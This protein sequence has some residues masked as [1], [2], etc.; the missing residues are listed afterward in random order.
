MLDR[1]S[2]E[3]ALAR[4][5]ELEAREASRSDEQERDRIFGRL[6]E[7]SRAGMYLHQD[8]KIVLVNEQIRR[9]LDY[10][11]QELLGA[12]FIEFVH[13]DDR[14]VVAERA[15]ARQ[16][17][18]EAPSTYEFRL[19]RRDG[20]ILWVEVHVE[21]AEYRG[22]PA[23]AGSLLDV[24]NRKIAEQTLREERDKKD[25]LYQE[26]VRNAPA[27][28][29]EV[30]L[31]SGRLI[32]VNEVV[33]QYSGYTQ[34]ELLGMKPQDLFAP[35]SRERLEQRMRA[36]AAD[37]DVESATE[38]QLVAR[39]GSDVWV[40]V[41]T[42]VVY[43]D[44]KPVR[45]RSVASDIT[46]RKMAEE[47]LNRRVA[48]EGVLTSISSNF[49][50]LPLEKI[51]GGILN[52][53]S[54]ISRFA[55]AQRACIYLLSE[56]TSH[57]LP[58]HQWYE[59]GMNRPHPDLGSLNARSFAWLLERMKQVETIRIRDSEALGEDD[60]RERE[61]CGKLGVRS[62]IMIPLAQFGGPTGLLTFDTVDQ[63][64]QWSDEVITLVETA[65]EVFV[66][67]LER[68]RNEA[69][70]QQRD[71][72]LE[73]KSRQLE[74]VNRAL[75]TLLNQSKEDAKNI[76]HRLVAN[77]EDLV[78]PYVNRLRETDLNMDQQVYLKVIEENLEELMSPFMRRIGSKHANLTPR[79]VE[80][81]NLVRMGTTS[82]EIAKLLDISK[83][84]VEFHRDS[85][86]KKL[87]LKNKKRNLRAY[88]SSL[89]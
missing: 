74:E 46:E 70:L 61:L 88:L 21:Y 48:L 34:E 72:E 8:G 67:A 19:V 16:E 56:D 52:G 77:V 14:N 17:G 37:E 49:I 42:S 59:E 89:N 76:E 33:C 51:E 78:L 26:I 43:E 4:I 44:G 22:R 81:A 86:R 23:V 5:R 41:N 13:P 35:E 30:D 24:T 31:A 68:R 27:A 83:R 63:P 10:S 39:D 71:M 25:A 73:V 28:I 57:I 75:R 54:A 80:V 50:S 66:N 65:A 62:V 38:Y 84:A 11:E 36:M 82:K 18:R 85:L 29:I 79:E 15:A 40:V 60:V 87:G 7:N 55:G 2:Y 20:T 3:D 69:T 47:A 1:M 45:F 9:F 32:R 53:L 12:D 64:R 58:A 6:A